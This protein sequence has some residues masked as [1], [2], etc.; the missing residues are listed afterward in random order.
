[1]SHS[2]VQVKAAVL[3]DAF[4]LLGFKRAGSGGCSRE[5]CCCRVEGWSCCDERSLDVRRGGFECLSCDP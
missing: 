5:V 1:M 4:T 2:D 3:S